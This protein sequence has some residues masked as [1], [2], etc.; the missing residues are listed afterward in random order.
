MKNSAIF[1]LAAIFL[2]TAFFPTEAQFGDFMGSGGRGKRPFRPTRHQGARQVQEQRESSEQEPF[3]Q[4]QTASLL[5]ATAYALAPA[6]MEDRRGN[7][8]R[9]PLTLTKYDLSVKVVGFLAEVS[10]TYTFFNPAKERV[11]KFPER[12]QVEGVLEFSLP[13]GATVDGFALDIGNDMVDGVALGKER[14]TTIFNRLQRRNI[15]PGLVEWLGDGR[16]KCRIFPIFGENTRTIRIRYSMR[17]GESELVIPT[18]FDGNIAEASV[19]IDVNGLVRPPAVRKN[20]FGKFEFHR[21]ESPGPAHG[22]GI[23]MFNSFSGWG[24]SVGGNRYVGETKMRN[25]RSKENLLLDFEG[26]EVT[27]QQQ[28]VACKVGDEVFSVTRIPVENILAKTAAARREIEAMLRKPSSV[29]VFWDASGSRAEIDHA[30]E[31]ELLRKYLDEKQCGV[32]LYV[33]RDAVEPLVY[34]DAFHHDKLF[35]TLKTVAYDGGTSLRSIFAVSPVAKLSLLF[36]DGLETME[37]GVLLHDNAEVPTSPKRPFYLAWN[38]DPKRKS[39][40]FDRKDSFIEKKFDL[41]TDPADKI[42]QEIGDLSL[43]VRPAAVPSKFEELFI[44]ETDDVIWIY[45]KRKWNSPAS[46]GEAIPVDINWTFGDETVEKL[47]VS[48][49][50][51]NAFVEGTIPKQAYIQA[52]FGDLVDGAKT[53]DTLR[54]FSVENTL[55]SPDC[56]LLVLES[57]GQYLQFDLEPPA[58]SPKLLEEYRRRK[59]QYSGSSESRRKANRTTVEWRMEKCNKDWEKILRWWNAPPTVEKAELGAPRSRTQKKTSAKQ[60]R[61]WKDDRS[62]LAF[63]YDE[64]NPSPFSGF[65]SPWNIESNKENPDGRGMS[66]GGAMFGGMGGSGGGMGGGFST[67]RGSDG[68]LGGGMGGGSFGGSSPLSTPTSSNESAATSRVSISSGGGSV[69]DFGPIMEILEA[70]PDD[71]EFYKKYAQQID[72][73]GTFSPEKVYGVYLGVRKT[74]CFDPMF[75]FISANLFK[76]TKYFE[77]ILSNLYELGEGNDPTVQRM[78]GY[79]LLQQRSPI[80]ARFFQKAIAANEDDLSSLRGLAL[81]Y[82]FSYERKDNPYEKLFDLSRNPDR[83]SERFD[84]GFR[85]IAAV[86]RNKHMEKREPLDV[87][88]RIIATASHPGVDFS[89]VV[90][91]PGHEKVAVFHPFSSHGGYLDG[92]AGIANVPLLSQYMIRHA[93]RGRYKIEIECLDLYKTHNERKKLPP[94]WPG[95]VFVDVNSKGSRPQLKTYCIPLD[96]K[97]TVYEIDNLRF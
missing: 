96:M 80:A 8:P 54:K 75:Y 66:G 63:K 20:G 17:I 11:E 83:W 26:F 47:P 60:F 42:V 90:T 22:F 38:G 81:A 85:R 48:L 94:L 74:R 64:N 92:S 65:S 36:T 10:A 2:L 19:K 1:F 49:D 41:A 68:L 29:A 16:F 7:E 69:A 24:E 30:K 59:Q 18:A 53:D 35:E 9:L 82:G 51:R 91:E 43:R 97:K 33:F 93:S 58:T 23:G 13:D 39:S 71:A 5:P 40:V 76:N 32:E 62:Y 78:V 46:V 15:D 95:V 28:T 44:D 89:L 61:D 37:P 3:K 21:G 72:V 79:L 70:I 87:D 34:F 57:V 52:K 25:V 84:F 56:S 31:F 50:F 73:A 86:E 77:R 4:T 12:D 14:A 67:R 6:T 88:L 27:T 45:G 55:V